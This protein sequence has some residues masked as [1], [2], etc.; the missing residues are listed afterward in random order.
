MSK[1]TRR[2]PLAGFAGSL[3][4]LVEAVPAEMAR[5]ASRTATRPKAATLAVQL[6]NP[7]GPLAQKTLWMGLPGDSG[8][9]PTADP[10]SDLVDRLAGL[11]AHLRDRRPHGRDGR[12]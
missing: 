12:A 2:A 11:L 3:G 9:L 7:P 6:T 5:A 8:V 1:V 4:G 10:L